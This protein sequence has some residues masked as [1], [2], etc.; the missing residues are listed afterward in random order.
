MGEALI[1]PE[2]EQ[3]EAHRR[4]LLEDSDALLLQVEEL[5]LANRRRV[6]AELQLAIRELQARVGRVDRHRRLTLNRAHDAIFAIQDR[7]MAANPRRITARQHAGRAEGTAVVE[8][9]RP[10]VAWKLLALPP[11]P[12]APE[13][14]DA[15]LVHVD[16]TVERA[17]ERWFYAQHHAVAAARLRRRAVAALMVAR[18]AWNNYWELAQ[19]A[20]RIRARARG[21]VGGPK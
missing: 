16:A 15:W 20:D 6:P 3:S 12:T 18:V 7:L 1:L 13:H 4:R 9:I 10:G 14:V 8:P 11:Q 5:R 17:L 2:R 19:D 21:R